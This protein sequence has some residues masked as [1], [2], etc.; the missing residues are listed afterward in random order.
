MCIQEVLK[1][2]VKKDVVVVIPVVPSAAP[3]LRASPA[4]HQRFASITQHFS[5][6]TALAGCPTLTLPVGQL[7]DGTPLSLAMFGPQRTDQ[8]LLAVAS[9]MIPHIQVRVMVHVLHAW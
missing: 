7:E 3:D 1:G 2:A 6:I 4:V 5:S 9:K 8:R